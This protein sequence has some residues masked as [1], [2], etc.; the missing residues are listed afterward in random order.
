MGH[1]NEGA[2]LADHGQW[3]WKI[4]RSESAGSN[5]GI[6]VVVDGMAYQGIL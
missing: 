4:D 1:A 2:R 6:M 5:G 3:E